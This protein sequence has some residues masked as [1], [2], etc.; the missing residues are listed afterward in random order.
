MSTL[1]DDNGFLDKLTRIG[2]KKHQQKKRIVRLLYL[3]G[4]LTISEIITSMELSAPTVQGLLDELEEEGLVDSKGP[5]TSKGGRRPNLFGLKGDAFYILA[6]D[7]GRQSTRVS[8]FNNANESVTGVQ[9]IPLILENKM[10]VVDQIHQFANEVVADSGIDPKRIVGVG[11]DMPGLVDSEKGIN[12]SYLNFNEPV[13]SIFEDRF[14]RP[15]FVVNDAQSKASAEFRF[16]LA[17][18]KKNVLVLHIGSGLGTGMIL[19]G[20]PYF[21]SKGFSGEFSHIHVVEKGYLC[22]C[23]KRGCLETLA[24][25]MALTRNV[26][27]SLEKGEESSI[28]EKVD[29]D[30]TKINHKIILDAALNGDQFA[31]NHLT[32]LGREL[33]KGIAI[34]VQIINPELI[35]LGGRIA[36]AGKY[37]TIPIEQALF[38]YTIPKIREDL[39]IVISKLGDKANLLGSVICVMENVFEN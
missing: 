24:S 17:R 27:A 18:G 34:L 15:V 39:K 13:R 23:G 25:G 19:D 6:I 2:L 20:K 35:I 37:L 10:E 26:I 16:G 21:G 32:E 31:I 36:E 30:V 38:Q 33:G 9:Y 1:I 11:I 12:Y 29:N 3:Q 28:L 8:V 5:G 22:N 4:A 7:I 14:N